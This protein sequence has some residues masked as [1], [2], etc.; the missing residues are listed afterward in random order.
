MTD[1]ETTGRQGNDIGRVTPPRPGGGRASHLMSGSEL[2]AKGEGAETF[3][4]GP[5]PPHPDR[6]AGAAR[7]NLSPP[8]RGGGSSSG[9]LRR[10]RDLVDAGLIAPEQAS[11]LKAVAARYAVAITPAMAELIDAADPAD[12]IARQ[13]V[14]DPVELARTATE[15]DD[16]IGDDAHEV[17]PGLIHRYPDRA[18]LKLTS[19]CAVYCR[20]CFRRETVGHGGALSPAEIDAA[21]A[22]VRGRPEIWEVIVSGGDPL[23][24]GPR[25]LKAL[26]AALAEIAHVGVVRFHTRVPVVA[27]ERVTAA[28]VA[29]LKAP[30]KATW[31]A[32][33]ANHPR[34][35]TAAARAALARLSQANIPL[36]SQTVLLKGVND[37]ADTLA[38]LMRAFVEAQ[39]K[40]YYLHH[41]DLA[42]GT[43]HFR[44]T[45]GEGQALMKALRGR[46]SGLCQPTYVLDI[47]GG[48]GKAP[49]G[50]NYVSDENGACLVEDFAGGRHPYPPA[51]GTAVSG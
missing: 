51:A 43:G 23:V 12:P 42:P 39:V 15:R 44:T 27:P 19:A 5:I 21:L 30:G 25:R 35:L 33:H 3:P 29:A 6:P 26:T 50:P 46:L 14:P 45:I 10:V 34:E 4:E 9:T 28:L 41:G 7:S 49:V 37:D 38:R 40:P 1:I 13:F 32:I 20:F 17:A 2:G 47:P 24:A 18:L 22:Y 11:A 48:H 16:P 36:V 8:G 31:V